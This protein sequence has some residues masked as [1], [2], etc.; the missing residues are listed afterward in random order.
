MRWSRGARRPHPVPP[1]NVRAVYDDGRE[2]PIELVYTGVD[3][4][5][6]HHWV[7]VIELGARPRE[8]RAGMLPARSRITVRMRGGPS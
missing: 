8:L 5:G 1:E 2:V 7:A 4:E 3:A 6:L